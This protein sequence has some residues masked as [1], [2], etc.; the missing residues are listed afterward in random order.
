MAPPS[1]TNLLPPIAPQLPPLPVR[2]FTVEEY[3]R[4][5][6]AGVLSEDDR[7]ELLEGWI[8]PKMVHN[9]RHDA[10]IA[11]LSKVLERFLPVGSHIRVQSV[12]TTETSEP[13]PDLAL[14][15]GEATRYLKHHPRPGE[16]LLVIEVADS[17]LASDREFKG[18]IYARARI[19]VYWI[20]NLVDDAVEVY[21][22]PS[23]PGPAPAYR[24]HRTFARQD[25]VP[26]ALAQKELGAIPGAELLP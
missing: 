2:R 3:Q 1:T 18:S 26:L 9:P 5:G 14:V 20:V 4:M 8:V 7:V 19:P 24:T 21:T 25:T 13:E 15:V 17:S 16:T 11:H 6:Q 12:I 22:D 23:G 10:T